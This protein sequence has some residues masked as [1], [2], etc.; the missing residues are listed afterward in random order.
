MC[1]KRAWGARI[2]LRSQN[3]LLR[4]K[5]FASHALVPRSP[6]PETAGTSTTPAGC[7][8]RLGAC[9][10][11]LARPESRRPALLSSQRFFS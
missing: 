10:W 11:T 6:F 4:S 1:L 5:I 8:H 3:R 9:A 7:P 2:S